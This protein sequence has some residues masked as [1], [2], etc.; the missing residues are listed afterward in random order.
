[1]ARCYSCNAQTV[2]SLLNFGNQAMSNRF[3]SD[4]KMVE[5]THPL[6]FGYC[7]SCGLAQLINPPE[8]DMLRPQVDWIHYNEPEGHLDAVA[9]LLANLPGVTPKSA[10]AG[11]SGKESS[12]L[13]RLNHLGFSNTWSLNL[14]GDLDIP[15]PNSGLETLQSALTPETAQLIARKRGRAKIL[16]ARHILEHAQTPQ[17]FMAALREL[18]SEDGYIIFEVPDC[19]KI[20][21]T[22]EYSAIW[23][24]HCMYF[25]PYTFK[26]ILGRA[27]FSIYTMKHYP[28]VMENCMVAITQP[29]SKSSI[30]SSE[31]PA[32][33]IKQLTKFAK[34][35]PLKRSQYVAALKNLQS[36]GKLSL[37]G[38]GHIACHFINLFGLREFFHFVV[39]DHPRK[40][41][42]YMPGSKLPILPTQHLVSEN[43]KV[44]LLSLNQESEEKVAKKQ[45]AFI[46]QGGKFYSIFSTSQ[47]ALM[48][49]EPYEM[50]EN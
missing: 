9:E 2:E 3:I 10:I 23:E 44:C 7:S 12:L 13:Q 16:I 26:Q 27:N 36:Q 35:Y 24:E 5:E 45:Q 19:S 28:Y 50:A 32:N 43:I 37:L 11:I 4:P 15:T 38:A 40:C 41:G 42:L 39:D 29:C 22:C 18:V 8:S 49:A 6:I 30:D 47:N 21:S 25:T 46:A 31:S 17:I 48:M 33:E 20:F 34:L 14:C 1:M